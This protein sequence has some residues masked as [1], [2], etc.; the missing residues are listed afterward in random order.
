MIRAQVRGDGGGVGAWQGA[1]L[2]DV[3]GDGLALCAA[4]QDVGQ[5]PAGMA[6]DEGGDVREGRGGVIGQHVDPLQDLARGP[7]GAGGGDLQRFSAALG[8]VRGLEEGE[9][10]AQHPLVAAGL[11]LFCI[12]PGEVLP[13]AAVAVGAA[14]ATVVQARQGGRVAVPPARVAELAGEET[15][16]LAGTFSSSG[17][18]WGVTE[19]LLDHFGENAAEELVRRLEGRRFKLNLIPLNPAPEIPFSA[20]T[21]GDVDA[22]AGILVAGGL[23]TDLG[24]EIFIFRRAAEGHTQRIPVDLERLVYAADPALNLGVAPNDIIY[25]PTIE[26]VRIFVSGAVTNPDVYE[27]PRDEPI[28]IRSLLILPSSTRVPDWCPR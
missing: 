5:R 28:T 14:E 10:V 22:F 21:P 25:V 3:G 26:K 27:V 1:A 16:V 23:D 4:A 24:K 2:V 15:T 9:V 20:P 17:G 13:A 7:R 12:D 18:V 11:P 6:V 8:A 19:A